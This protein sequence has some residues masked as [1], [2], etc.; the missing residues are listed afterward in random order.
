MSFSLNR[1]KAILDDALNVRIL[2]S[3]GNSIVSNSGALRVSTIGSTFNIKASDS[4]NILTTNGGIR[5][6]DYTNDLIN[7]YYISGSFTSSY[8]LQKMNMYRDV[9]SISGSDIT[10]NTSD[11]YPW[12]PLGCFLNVTSSSSDDNSTGSG[13]RTIAI[14]GISNTN[15][16]STTTYTM[17]GTSNATSLTADSYTS[18]NSVIVLTAGSDNSNVGKIT[19]TNAST[20]QEVCNIQPKLSVSLNSNL[21]VIPGTSAILRNLNIQTLGPCNVYLMY[22]A[23]GTSVWKAIDMCLVNGSLSKDICFKM[24]AGDSFKLYGVSLSGSTPLSAQL[25]YIQ[26]F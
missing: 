19:I 3:S 14:N 24:S 26:M 16:S 8:T 21:T 7:G 4:T 9:V 20:G 11:T 18:I 12:F 25:E 13:A 23:F 5:T 15:V 17:N 2:D 1:D 22:L 6:A 10:T